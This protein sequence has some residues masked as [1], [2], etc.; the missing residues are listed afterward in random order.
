M[1]E[2][3]PGNEGRSTAPLLPMGLLRAVALSGG[4]FKLRFLDFQF[5]VL[6]CFTSV[7]PKVQYFQLPKLNWCVEKRTHQ[8]KQKAVSKSQSTL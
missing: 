2:R 6:P 5:G 7:V 3:L 8:S 1:R 4:F